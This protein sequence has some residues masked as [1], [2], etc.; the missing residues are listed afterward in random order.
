[1]TEYSSVPYLATIMMTKLRTTTRKVVKPNTDVEEKRHL[2]I[3]EERDIASKTIKGS[4]HAEA[5]RH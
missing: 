3:C 2:D 1:M 4:R 5:Y